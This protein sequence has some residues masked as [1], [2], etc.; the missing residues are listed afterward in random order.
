MSGRVVLDGLTLTPETLMAIADG[1]SVEIAPAA[2][3]RV[4]SARRVVDRA[5]ADGRVVYG[6]NTG[7]GKFMNVPIPQ[8][9]LRLL[10]VNLIR[11]HAAGAPL[12]ASLPRSCRSCR[13]RTR[14]LSLVF[15]PAA[16]PLRFPSPWP[17]FSPPM[18]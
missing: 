4:R 11:S 2:W 14:C 1:A 17:C 7:F 3:A 13:R 16:Q 8:G 9:K 15:V 18:T 5:L 12:R 6:V 10:Q